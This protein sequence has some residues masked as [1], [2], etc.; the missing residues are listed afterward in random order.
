MPKIAN[1]DLTTV[2]QG[3]FVTGKNA[4]M[5]SDAV[6]KFMKSMEEVLTVQELGQNQ[7]QNVHPPTQV[8]IG[9]MDN[10]LNCFMDNYVLLR[11]TEVNGISG[12]ICDNCLSFQFQYIKEIGLDL[13]AGEKHQCLAS[14]V[15]EA[16]SLQYKTIKEDDIRIKAYEFLVILA[17]SIFM[18]KQH[19][20]VNSK[21]S[22]AHAR[23]LHAP[24]IKFDSITPNDWPWM[25]ITKET[26]ALDDKGLKN[27]IGLMGASTYA[28]IL[29]ERGAYFGYHLM[30]MERE[31][32][33]R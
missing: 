30:Y 12:H 16:N 6:K 22:T 8:S 1:Q 26:I 20:V 14:M 33:N 9:S 23:S 13:T 3:Q 24:L 18:G 27:Y 32:V 7:N 29:S 19:L 31:A 25:P 15:N 5:Q 17:N 11:K 10:A 28:L 2:Q 4:T 21:L